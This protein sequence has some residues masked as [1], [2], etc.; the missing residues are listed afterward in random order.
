MGITANIVVEWAV[1]RWNAEVANRPLK[2]VHRRTLDDT[3]RQ[4][5]RQYGGDDAILCGPKH[6][7]LLV[8]TTKAP[9]PTRS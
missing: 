1:K 7:E 5:I 6:D 2:N 4:I 8:L 3:W 9:W